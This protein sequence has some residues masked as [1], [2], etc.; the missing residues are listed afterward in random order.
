MAQWPGGGNER[1]ADRPGPAGGFALA[2]ERGGRRALPRPARRVKHQAAGHEATLTG[3]A[4]AVVPDGGVLV[5]W[6]APEGH[7]N[8]LYTARLPGGDPARVRVNPHDLTVDSL[9]LP[10][11]LAAGPGGEIYLAWSSAKPK[12]QGALFASDLRLSRSLDGGRTFA[13]HL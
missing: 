3:A 5:A 1:R 6:A 8:H 11:R 12:P 2:G 10:P 9:H 13:G 4:L 7:A